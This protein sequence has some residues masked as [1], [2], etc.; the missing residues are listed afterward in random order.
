MN[1]EIKAIPTTAPEPCINFRPP[2]Y[3]ET[4]GVLTICQGLRE[5]CVFPTIFKLPNDKED[6]G[7]Y[8]LARQLSRSPYPTRRSFRR[9]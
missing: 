4:V 7:Q 5:K 1:K 9:V 8:S 6:V 2:G 3:C